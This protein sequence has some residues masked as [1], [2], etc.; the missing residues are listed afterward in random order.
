MNSSG[1]EESRV[2]RGAEPLLRIVDTG[3]EPRDSAGTTTI[4]PWEIRIGNH[5]QSRDSHHLIGAEE[6]SVVGL[7]EIETRRDIY[8]RQ[9]LTAFGIALGLIFIAEI[10]DKTQL[11]VLAFA[12]RHRSLPVLLG[13]LAAASAVSAISVAVG[14][15]IGMALPLSWI[16][17]FAGIAFIVF[18]LWTLK[19]EEEDENEETH[20]GR[21]GPF[22]TVF[23]AFFVA[24]IGDKTM[25]ATIT[26]SSQQSSA[27]AVWAGASLGLFFANVLAVVV[28][29]WAGTSL[30]EKPIRW[31]A[32]A[33]FI[34]SG[35]WILVTG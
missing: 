12:T 25:L 30:P 1:R 6:E 4:I 32:A 26:I 7:S 2:G 20:E 9:M 11:M 8:R 35:I 23:L 18:G 15:A 19:G 21:F 5:G 33:I 10:G 28:G 34:A 14:S 24:E 27:V 29:R 17:I 13:V 22:L 16:R 31:T 3:P